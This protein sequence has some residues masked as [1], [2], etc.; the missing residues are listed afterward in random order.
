MK[1]RCNVLNGLNEKSGTFFKS[2]GLGGIEKIVI[3]VIIQ[4]KK[5]RGTFEVF[6]AIHLHLNSKISLNIFKGQVFTSGQQNCKRD[7]LFYKFRIQ[8]KLEPGK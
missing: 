5:L 4:A 8:R 6:F 2:N 1:L 7:S 3:M